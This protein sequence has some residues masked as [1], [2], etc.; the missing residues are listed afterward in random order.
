[1]RLTEN[2]AALLFPDAK[3]QPKAKKVKTPRK[4]SPGEAALIMQLNAEKIGGWCRE[5]QFHPTRKWRA[6]FAWIGAML[7][8]EIEGAVYVQGRHSRGAGMEADCEKYS[9]AACLGFKVI[10]VTTRMV[11]NGKALDYIQRILRTTNQE[12]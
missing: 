12:I 7:L 8:V 2:E 4:E 11:K 9:E 6:D 5:Y 1:M 3:P 10:R